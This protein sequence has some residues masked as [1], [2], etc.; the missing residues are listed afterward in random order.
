MLAAVSPKTRLSW[1][2][3]KYETQKEHT[4]FAWNAY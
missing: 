2:S 4:F 1:V 3:S